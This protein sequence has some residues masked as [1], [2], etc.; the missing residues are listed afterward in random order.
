MRRRHR[1]SHIYV[2]ERMNLNA[3]NLSPYRYVI[4]IFETK[5]RLIISHGYG[6][7]IVLLKFMNSLFDYV[8]AVHH[9]CVRDDQGRSKPEYNRDRGSLKWVKH[10]NSL[11]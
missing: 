1:D 8:N 2:L 4:K 3:L 5:T 11:T 10:K 6:L 7:S 9:L